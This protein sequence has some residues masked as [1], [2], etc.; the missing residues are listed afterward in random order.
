MDFTEEERN[1]ARELIAAALDEDLRIRGDVTTQA[2][3][4]QDQTGAV[5]VV[6]HEI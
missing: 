4:P 5:K 6:A 2:L 1:R 3:I